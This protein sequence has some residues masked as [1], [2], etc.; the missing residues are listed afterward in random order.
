MARNNRELSQ[1]GAFISITDNSQEID[2]GT[3]DGNEVSRHVMSIGAVDNT[4]LTV[5]PAIGIGTTNPGKDK[6]T[7]LANVNVARQIGG[8]GGNLTVD[9]I[10]RVEGESEI[11]G[12]LHLN[13]GLTAD[14]GGS[15]PQ[16]VALRVTHGI[17]EFGNLVE[18]D[19]TVAL[20][21]QA[22]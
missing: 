12:V 14:M 18:I 6:V 20:R 7:V 4:G 1:L 8:E 22:E 10:L 2:A 15:D 9:Q 16:E 19:P 21:N 17:S 13:G 11:K 5:P 3:F